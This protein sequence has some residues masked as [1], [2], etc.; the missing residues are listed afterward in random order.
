MRNWTE[1]IRQSDTVLS[2]I[3]K[4]N[5]AFLLFHDD[6]DGCC[7]AA[8]LLNL[9]SKQSS[10]GFFNFASPEKHSVELTARLIE[11]LRRQKP[12]SIVS[13]DLALTSSAEK[14][15]TLLSFLDAQML[16]YDH[17]VQSQSIRWPAKCTHIN[18]FNFSLGNIPASYYSYILHKHYIKDSDA[19]W[20]A[21]VGT[22]TDYRAEEGKDLLREVKRHYPSLYPFKTIDQPTALRSPLMT[23]GHL[24]NAGYQHSD[25]S[26]AKMAVEALRE[27]LEMNDPAALLKGKT[28]KAKLLHRFREE[29]DEELNKYLADFA[30]EAEFH[31]DSRL[32]F[33][34]IKPK[35]NITS[36]IA[37]EL[38]HRN[39]NTIIAVI[40]PET[41]KTT[42]VSLRRGNK[43]KTDL[44][45]LAETT[46]ANLTRASGGGHRDAAGCTLPTDEVNLWKK[47]IS[48]YLSR[49]SAR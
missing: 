44:A 17:H 16:T 10:H 43:V 15:N 22:V 5:S 11:K 35:F 41:Q 49:I 26:G 47:N 8:V 3:F 4:E 24:V 18:P 21:G 13:L 34:S 19:S 48:Q 31:M 45:A 20:V 25:S 28:A 33:Y 40:S 7:A 23:I 12:K 30:S 39:P 14:I 1:I 46:T 36:Q 2:R 38:Q 27:A 42:K 29:I 32:A 9:V 37:T 6:A